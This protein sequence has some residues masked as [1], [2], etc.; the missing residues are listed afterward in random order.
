MINSTEAF[1]LLRGKRTVR[2]SEL[3]F[4]SSDSQFQFIGMLIAAAPI[5]KLHLTIFECEAFAKSKDIDD[6]RKV[7]LFQELLSPSGV[8]HKVHGLLSANLLDQN[9]DFK[10]L[11]FMARQMDLDPV[12]CADELRGLM[13]RL[14]A[15]MKGRFIN[16]FLNEAGDPREEM[17]DDSFKGPWD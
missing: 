4:G 15:S 9:S 1:R 5:D 3:F 11:A 2:C 14:S 17:P 13:L 10:H 16:L 8:L 7:G 6:E 12:K